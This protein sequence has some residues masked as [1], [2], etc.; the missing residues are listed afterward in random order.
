MKTDWGVSVSEARARG[1]TSTRFMKVAVFALF[2]IASI[3]A[4][5]LLAGA[6]LFPVSSEILLDVAII[7]V[8]I[9][10]ALVF[11]TLSKKGAR[12]ALQIDYSA[13]EIRLGAVNHRGAFVRHRVCPFST[14]DDV[15]AREKVPGAPEL[16]LIVDDEKLTLRFLNTQITSLEAIA[17]KISEAQK[18]AQMHP[19]RTRIKS[20]IAGLEASYLEVGQRVRSRVVSHTV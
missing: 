4:I 3:A 10:C 14:I 5:P 20:T 1:T 16:R 13:S 15:Y 9:L 7:V 18:S 6:L 19:V 12:N 2:F 8:F 17:N 11:N